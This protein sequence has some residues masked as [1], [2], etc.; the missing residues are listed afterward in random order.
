MPWGVAT[1]PSP[2][3]RWCPRWTTG[4]RFRPIEWG[5]QIQSYVLDK[6]YV[7]D[8]RTGLMRFDPQNVLDGD[9]MDLIW[10]GLEWKAGRREAQEEALAED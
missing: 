8:H 9:L 4:W 6:Q 1:P 7:K 5:S 3:W 10:A 2:G